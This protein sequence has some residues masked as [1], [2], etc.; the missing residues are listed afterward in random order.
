MNRPICLYAALLLALATGNLSCERLWTPSDPGNDPVSNFELLWQNLDRKYSFFTTKGIN[1]DSIYTVYRPQIYVGMN[2]T[3]LFQTLGSMI[4]ELEDGHTDLRSPY[5]LC[6]FDYTLGARRNFI[7]DVVNVTYLKNAGLEQDG[8]IY[9]IIDSVGYMY[10]GSF[11][12]AITEEGIREVLQYFNGTKGIIIDVRNNTGGDERHG[13]IIA[14]HFFDHRRKVAIKHFKTGPGHN[15]FRSM[16]IYMEPKNGMQLSVQTVILT[17][18]ACYS[19]CNSFVGWM[20]SLPHVD[21]VGDTTGGGGGTPYFS[22]LPNGWTYRYSATRLFRPDGLNMDEGIPPDH[23]VILTS[24]DATRWR[25][26][27]IEF[28]LDLIDP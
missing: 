28:A 1:W 25:D 18:R 13:S 2:D 8:I 3:Q 7:P 24:R 4:L 11:T 16:D 23:Y 10:V 21:I 5:G 12:R 9:H 26:S 27:L 14:N 20:S 15:D 22:E 17:N 19:T 6:E